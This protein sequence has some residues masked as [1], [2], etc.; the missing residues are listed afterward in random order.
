MKRINPCTWGKKQ[1]YPRA[2]HFP[3]FPGI[4][5]HRE[6]EI[7]KNTPGIE[8]REPPAN[9]ARSLRKRISLRYQTPVQPEARERT[10][11]V[12]AKKALNPDGYFTILIDTV[13]T[14]EGMDLEDILGI[15]KT[16]TGAKEALFNLTKAYGLCEKL[17]GLEKTKSSCFGY[18]LG[19]CKGACCNKEDKR[20]YNGRFIIAFSTHQ[21][22]KPWPF[23]GAV[24]IIE[25]NEEEELF[26]TFVIRD[27]RIMSFMRGDEIYE[28]E[29]MFDVD[30]YK[31]LAS[32]LKHKKPKM[33]MHKQD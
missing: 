1:E 26:E 9:W 22:F 16:K 2:R 30:T 17:M 33:R 6:L 27:W 7:I 31:I 19:R 10:P 14:L 24:E 18:K 23:N 4:P 25:K 5:S 12:I 3:F 13:A 29:G 32:H 11:Y 20:I 21:E 8:Y 28:S 15:Y